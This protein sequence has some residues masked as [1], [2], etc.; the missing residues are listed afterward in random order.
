M[1]TPQVLYP[2][3]VTFSLVRLKAYFRL[4]RASPVA[5]LVKSLP[6]AQGDRGSIPGSRR[7]LGGGIGYPLLYSWGSLVS[8]TV[9]NPS[10]MWEAWV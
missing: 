9:E 3:E 7:S 8:Q 6:T 2:N 4:E 10:A 5:H 1:S